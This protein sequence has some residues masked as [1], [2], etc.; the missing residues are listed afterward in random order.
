[1]SVD[2]GR[3]KRVTFLGNY[4]SRPTF[5]PDGKKITMV[6]GDSQGYHI[7]ILDIESGVM[8]VLTDGQLDESPS[9]APNGST[10]LYAT[11]SKNRGV[12]SAVSSDG[13]VKQ[14]LVLQQGDVREPAWAPYRK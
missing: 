8:N 3:A 14:R 4:N 6:H 5:S 2:G 7:A 9:F 12:L 1:M 11:S 10:I 13:K